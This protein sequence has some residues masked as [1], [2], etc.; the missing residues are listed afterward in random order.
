MRIFIVVALLIG[1]IWFNPDLQ[2]RFVNSIKDPVVGVMED[3]NPK[4]PAFILDPP[5]RERTGPN[6]PRENP[7]PLPERGEKPKLNSDPRPK[8]S[9]GARPDLSSEPR[10]QLTTGPRPGAP[11]IVRPR[12]VDT[13]P[14]PGGSGKPS[15][16]LPD[17]LAEKRQNSKKSASPPPP[18]LGVAVQK[19]KDL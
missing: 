7:F 9:P 5:P 16:K 10:P 8:L 17:P 4:R 1:V 2:K 13:G 3:D 15:I 18:S 6:K 12:G 11:P 19:A 14:K